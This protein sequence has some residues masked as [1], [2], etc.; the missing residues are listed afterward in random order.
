ARQAGETLEAS[1]PEEEE[2]AE[3]RAIAE[4]RVRLGLLLAEVGRLNNITVTQDEVNRAMAEQARRF[5]GQERQV[6][7]FFQKNPQA[8]ASLRAPI[9]EEKVCD[10]FLEMAQVTERKVGPD[11][12]MRDPDEEE[13]KP[14]G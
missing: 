6:F 11:E 4:R 7:E 5:P 9:L 8:Q 1:K 3:Y 2:K 12:L 13:A 14:A 10:F